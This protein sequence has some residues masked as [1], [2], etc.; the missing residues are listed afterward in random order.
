MFDEVEPRSVLISCRDDRRYF[1]DFQSAEDCLLFRTVCYDVSVGGLDVNRWDTAG[2]GG[3][4]SGR[5]QGG[6]ACGRGASH[7]W[8]VVRG[9]ARRSRPCAE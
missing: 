4:V 5:A 2:A 3:R 1:V 8:L 6:S 7:V 9:Q